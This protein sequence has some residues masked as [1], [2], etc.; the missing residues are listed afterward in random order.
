M[1]ELR[2]DP[3]DPTRLTLTATMTL[4]L[5][6]LLVETLSPEI[7]RAIREQAAKDIRG[8]KAV[9]KAISSAAQAHLM[10]LLGVEE[11]K[12]EGEENG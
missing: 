12:I 3:N 1:I 6:R 10:K 11:P 7:E 5:D 8:S 2:Q 4:F 9:R